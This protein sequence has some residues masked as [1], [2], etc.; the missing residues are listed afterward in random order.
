V[1]ERVNALASQFGIREALAEYLAH[2]KL[3]PLRVGQVFAV[4]AN[5]IMDA[6]QELPR[7]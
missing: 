5:S 7:N 6:R 3:E 1:V 4:V 2:A